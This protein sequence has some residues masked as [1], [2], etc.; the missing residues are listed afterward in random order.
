LY[1][2]FHRAAHA[3]RIYV[4]ILEQ[5]IANSGLIDDDS[6][7]SRFCSDYYLKKMTDQE[8]FDKDC[9]Q[10]KNQVRTESFDAKLSKGVS[11]ARSKLSA[12]I[13]W[14]YKHRDDPKLLRFTPVQLDDF[15]LQIDSHSDFIDQYDV[16]LIQMFH[17]AQNDYAVLSTYPHDVTLH[18]T[19]DQLSLPS[20]CLV[21]F[22]SS[23]RVWTTQYC[24]ALVK[25]KLSTAVFGGGMSFHRSHAEINVPVDPYLDHVF[26]GDD[27]SR[28]IRFFTHGYDVYTPDQNVV[29]HDYSM[30]TEAAKSYFHNKNAKEPSAKD[31]PYLKEII[32]N[33]LKVKVFGTERINM[34]L[35]I[36]PLDYSKSK[37]NRTETER[38]R[39]GRY[40]FGPHR[41]LQQASNFTGINFFDRK[42]EKNKCGNLKWVPYTEGPNYGVDAS[43]QKSSPG[44]LLDKSKPK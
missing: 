40:G 22:L 4:R 41:T 29:F 21:E 24:E 35:G 31:W 36:G 27:G 20:L 37:E 14:D 42:M 23:I 30:S 6:C 33:R 43:M 44:E 7:W 9:N 26:D 8:G 2:I 3:D 15:V 39:T 25:P 38:I 17:R 34:L 1:N 12:M 28:G 16:S 10:Y 11:N 13:E 19:S 32:T 5:T 18:N